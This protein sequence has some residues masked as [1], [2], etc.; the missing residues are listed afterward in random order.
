M[1]AMSYGKRLFQALPPM[2]RID[3]ES[4]AMAWLRS[5]AGAAVNA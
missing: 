5:L 3:E 2:T 4:E 1:A